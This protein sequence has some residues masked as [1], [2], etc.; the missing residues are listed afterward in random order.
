M[1]HRTI[2]WRLNTALALLVV[3]L[4]VCFFVAFRIESVR[5]NAVHL[6]DELENARDRVHLDLIQISD[7]VRGLVLDPK[8]ETDLKRRRDA[9]AALM[10][11]IES[12]LNPPPDHPELSDAIK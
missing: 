8:N 4:S 10:L 1:K 9:E 5:L 3:L 6:S 11:T 2:W 7:A 12:V